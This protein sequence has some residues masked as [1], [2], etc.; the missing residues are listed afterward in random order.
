MQIESNQ[1]LLM[2]NNSKVNQLPIVGVA[3]FVIKDKKILMGKRIG[4][5]GSNTWSIP[6]GHFEKGESFEEACARETFEETDIKVSDIRFVAVTNDYF[7]DIDKHY[8]TIWFTSKYESGEVEVKEPN[9]FVELNWYGFENIPSPLFFPW[10]QL[11]KSEFIQ[12]LTERIEN[13]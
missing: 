2:N 10:E 6:G 11:L 9:K 7:Q 13:L 3:L 4:S 5:H 1:A 12:T 8:V